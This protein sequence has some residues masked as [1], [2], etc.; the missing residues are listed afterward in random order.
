MFI[1]STFANR[2]KILNVTLVFLTFLFVLYQFNL[3]LA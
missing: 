2:I 3:V 1:D